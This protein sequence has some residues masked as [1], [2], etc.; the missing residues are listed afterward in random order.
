MD[1]VIELKHM[2]CKS[3]AMFSIHGSWLNLTMASL[4]GLERRLRLVTIYMV[5]L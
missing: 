2:L 4:I 3:L 1:V 5:D